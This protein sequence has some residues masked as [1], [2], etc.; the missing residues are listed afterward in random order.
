[1]GID[2]AVRPKDSSVT[3][4]ATRTRF[5]HPLLLAALPLTA[6]AGCAGLGLAF[7]LAYLNDRM[8]D[9]DGVAEALGL[10]VL[11]QIPTGRRGERLA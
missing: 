3:R 11:G 2:A 9:A 7:L 1:M 5:P 4:P 10:P 8:R 6:L